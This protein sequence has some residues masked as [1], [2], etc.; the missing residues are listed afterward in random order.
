MKQKYQLGATVITPTGEVGKI[1]Y[2]V[3]FDPYLDQ[4]RYKVQTATSRVT[5]NED[6]LTRKPRKNPLSDK[7]AAKYAVTNRERKD[8]SSVHKTVPVSHAHE[9]FEAEKERLGIKRTMHDENIDMGAQEAHLARVN[10]DAV[11]QAKSDYNND[12][13][14]QA[15]APGIIRVS[16]KKIRLSAGDKDV[17][18]AEYIDTVTRIGSA[19]ISAEKNPMDKAMVDELY[20]TFTNDGRIYNRYQSIVANLMRKANKGIYDHG[21]AVKAFMYLADDGAKLY[22][23]DFPGTIIDKPTRMAVAKRYADDFLEEHMS[24]IRMNP[25]TKGAKDTYPRKRSSIAELRIQGREDKKEGLPPMRPKSKPYMYGYRGYDVDRAKAGL[26][27]ISSSH[28]MPAKRRGRPKGALN[29]KTVRKIQDEQ[30]FYR[31]NPNVPYMLKQSDGSYKRRMAKV[32]KKSDGSYNVKMNPVRHYPKK[33]RAGRPSEEHY[34]ILDIVSKSGK[35]TTRIGQGTKEDATFE[36]KKSI[37]ANVKSATLS[38][39]YIKK[40]TSKTPRR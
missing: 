3:G 26:S 23:R 25:R 35:T 33:T 22:K 15:Q 7:L 8:W 28:T 17:W 21:K 18:L 10:R 36:A 40:P 11:K 2:V 27:K 32:T 5:Y 1:S 38:G 24:A 16:G 34:W 29:K 14:F 31:Y 6:S 13:A 9:R 20:L 37:T 30:D 19:D 4:Y 39:P 12:R